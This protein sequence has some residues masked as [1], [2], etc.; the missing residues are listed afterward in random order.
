MG[1]LLAYQSWFCWNLAEYSLA[2]TLL[3]QAMSLVQQVDDKQYLAFLLLIKGNI[4]MFGQGNNF[5]AKELFHQGYELYKESGHQMGMAISLN[6]MGGPYSHIGEYD[7]AKHLFQEAVA[8]CQENNYRDQYAQSNL[9]LGVLSENLGQYSEAITAYQTC[10]ELCQEAENTL[11]MLISLINQSEVML[12]MERYQDARDLSQQQLLL[13][14]DIGDRFYLVGSLAAL[15]NA[16]YMLDDFTAAWQ[17]L[18]ESL[19][20]V[21]SIASKP[22]TALVLAQIARL[23]FRL[24]QLEPSLILLIVTRTL[25]PAQHHQGNPEN[26]YEI[27]ITKISPEKVRVLEA[28]WQNKDLNEAVKIAQHEFEKYMECVEMTD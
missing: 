3:E 7:M 23:L 27:L 12:R 1:R 15:G 17:S 4:V 6:N 13:S 20:L 18:Q 22:Y 10:F 14:R 9:N 21:I 25:V 16:Y 26:L 19:D 2:N 11:G 5:Q 24:E 28:T 8:I